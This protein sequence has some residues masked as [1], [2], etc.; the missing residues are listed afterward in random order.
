MPNTA[1]T[2][3]LR[4]RELRERLADEIEER[5]AR[6]RY[7]IERRRVIFDAEMRHSHRDAREGLRSFL[8]RARPMVI[9]TAPLIYGL[10]I[11]FVI[12]DLF[13][14]VYQAVCFPIYGIE[15]VR[16]QDHIAI[17]RQH[18]AYLNALQKLNC[19]YCGYGNG[20]L[21][22][23]RAIA[24]RTEQYWCPIK[25]ARRLSD[26]HEN[27]DNFCDFGDAQGFRQNMF[28]L[29]DDLAPKNRP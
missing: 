28:R 17:D 25:H 18:L 8:S 29:R 21:S 6:F 19:V 14:T 12:L 7:H 15:K 20:L 11:P 23:V 13:V 26:T 22:Y 16:R 27:Y 10:I 4:I 1:E 9:L 2:L 24:G 3:V 5:R